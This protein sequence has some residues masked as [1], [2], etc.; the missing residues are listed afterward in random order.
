MPL[1]RLRSLQGSVGSRVHSVPHAK[2]CLPAPHFQCPQ[3]PFNVTRD[4]RIRVATPRGASF[5]QQRGRKATPP[6]VS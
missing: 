3:S 4:T 5:R 6:R 2:S 1:I